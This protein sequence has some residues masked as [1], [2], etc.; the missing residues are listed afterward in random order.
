MQ[1]LL[2][3][4]AVGIGPIHEEANARWRELNNT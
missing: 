2:V 3:S 4:A 1:A